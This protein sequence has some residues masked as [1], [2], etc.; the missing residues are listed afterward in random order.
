MKGKDR[1]PK[2]NWTGVVSVI[3]FLLLFMV[4]AGQIWAQSKG[5]KAITNIRID[6]NRDSVDLFIDGNTLLTYAPYIQSHPPVVNLYFNDT[7]LRTENVHLTPENDLVESVKATGD[8]GNG[9]AKVEIVLAKDIPSK[10]FRRGNTLKVSFDKHASPPKAEAVKPSA[11]PQY[12]RTRSYSA[13]GTRLETIYAGKIKDEHDKESVKVFIETNGPITRYESY[14]SENPARIVF[15]IYNVRSPYKNERTVPVYTEWVKRVRYNGYPDRL[16]VILDTKSVYL[17]AY[18]AYPIENGLIVHVGGDSSAQYAARPSQPAAPEDLSQRVSPSMSKN[19]FNSIYATQHDDGI[20][21]T[22]RAD[23]PITGFRPAINRNPPRIIY[24]ISDVDTSGVENKKI[25]IGAPEVKNIQYGSAGDKL[26]IVIE[27]SEPYLSAFSAYTDKTGMVIQI[28]SKAQA[29]RASRAGES[30]M[31]ADTPRAAGYEGQGGDLDGSSPTAWVNRID[32]VEGGQG[33]TTLIIGTTQEVEYEMDKVSDKKMLLKLYDAKIP[34]YRQRPLIT[35]KFDS[36][37]DT[38]KPIQGDDKM[39]EFSIELRETVPHYIEQAGNVLMVHFEPSA[40]QP[41]ASEM[42]GMPSWRNVL[43]SP[44]EQGRTRPAPPEEEPM[45]PMSI[46]DEEAMSPITIPSSETPVASGMDAFGGGVEDDDLFSPRTSQKQYTGEK[47]ALDFYKTDIKNVFRI[48]REVSGL[49]FAVEKDVTGEVTLTLDK[50]VPWDQVLDLV[51]KMNRLGKTVE[52]NIIR[53]ATQGTLNREAAEREKKREEELKAREARK[54]VEPLFTEYIPVNYS[55]AGS[56]IQP[57]IEKILTPERGS[58]SVDNR[59]NMIIMTDTRETI[60]KAVEIVE[61]LDRVTPQVIIEARVVEVNTNFAKQFG[62]QWGADAGIFN[63]DP[64]AG[65]GPQRS[66]S[67]L[68]GTYGY[69][70]SMNL[71]PSSYSGTLGFDFTR[72]AGTPFV[73]NA[74][75]RAM[76]SRSE[77]KIISAPKILTLDNKAAQIKQGVEI[78]YSVTDNEGNVNILFKNVDLLLE[79]TPHITPDNRISIVL[80]ITKN[81]IAGA[82][83]QISTKEA[84]TEFLINDGDTIVIGGIRKTN[85]LY[86]EDGFPGLSKIPLIGWLFKNKTDQEESQ[87][88]LIFITTKI[89]QLEQKAIRT[90]N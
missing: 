60:R 73:L 9:A 55:K 88:L 13:S 2:K 56:E 26:Q 52:G 28:G 78:P 27:T 7:I 45:E 76:E 10:V 63:D 64:A 62:V 47:I 74:R 32:F 70:M 83:Q 80:N 15:D 87:E 1:K 90:S 11:K 77:G 14:T 23:S 54:K 6:E 12:A 25:S 38:I 84:K 34:A 19:Q 43:E 71:P 31:R 8:A 33:K 58:V 30:G 57:H 18:N 3:G 67:V 89:V 5:V 50:P 36:A 17:D 41:K 59:T 37:V 85:I 29:A 40:K 86:G 51:L 65:I 46:S 16:R 53:I 72:I 75:L 68:G 49:N 81:D 66:Y 69:G 20:L 82:E 4:A 79:V 22:V 21:V 42:A 35:D 24:E 48:L 39:S 44:E 61:R